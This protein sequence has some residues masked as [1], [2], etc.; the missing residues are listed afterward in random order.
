MTD[1]GLFQVIGK[2]ALRYL[3]RVKAVKLWGAGEL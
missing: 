2:K 3:Q 1:G